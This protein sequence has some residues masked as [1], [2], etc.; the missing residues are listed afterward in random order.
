M[1][2]TEER[3]CSSTR[4]SS[5]RVLNDLSDEEKGKV[6]SG[7]FEL[8]KD[9]R[10]SQLSM[11][12]TL[13]SNQRRNEKTIQWILQALKESNCDHLYRLLKHMRCMLMRTE[14]DGKDGESLLVQDVREIQC[15]NNQRQDHF[16]NNASGNG[17]AWNA[18]E[19]S[20]FRLIKDKM[21]TNASQG[22]GAVVMDEEQT[23]FMASL[24]YEDPIYDEEGHHMTRII[25]LRSQVMYAFVDHLWMSYHEVHEMQI[26]VQHSYVV[27]LMTD[28]RGDRYWLLKETTEK[29]THLGKLDCGSQWDPTGFVQVIALVI[30]TQGCSKTYDGESFS[31]LMYLVEKFHGSMAPNLYTISF[32]EMMIVFPDMLAVPKASKSKSWLWHRSLKPFKLPAY[33]K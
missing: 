13:P 26:D 12:L 5:A 10:E 16:R 18:N 6:D 24:T 9:D 15:G 32:D 21:T 14:Y 28:I 17:V 2:V 23:M 25:H 8:N 7:S 33:D 22:V 19:T 27:D 4:S 30:W 11:N 29:G 20:R 1:V 3:G 31:K